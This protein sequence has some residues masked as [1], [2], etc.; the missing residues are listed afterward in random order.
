[1]RVLANGRH[2]EWSLFYFCL[3]LFLWEFSSQNK[4]S[5]D[6]M[7]RISSVSP[8]WGWLTPS[9][10]LFCCSSPLGSSVYS[11]DFLNGPIFPDFGKSGKSLIAVL[12]AGCKVKATGWREGRGG[13][14]F[15]E[16]E[17]LAGQICWGGLGALPISRQR[18]VYAV[19]HIAGVCTVQ[20]GMLSGFLSAGTDVTE[21]LRYAPVV[22][23]NIGGPVFLKSLEL[24]V[25]LHRLPCVHSLDQ[26]VD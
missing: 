22:R 10:D 14:C 25:P 6:C 5:H 2:K 18:A 24:G 15:S 23:L 7:Q 16:G 17:E 4:P 8:R 12:G 21:K 1:M 26:T 9:C 11:T 20:S 13:L 19:S 3:F